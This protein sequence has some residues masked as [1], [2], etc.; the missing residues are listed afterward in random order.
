MAININFVYMN[1][2]VKYSFNTHTTRKSLRGGGF[3]AI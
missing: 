2:H 1:Q 3:S